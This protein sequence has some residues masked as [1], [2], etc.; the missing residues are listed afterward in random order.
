MVVGMVMVET[1]DREP[2]RRNDHF[3]VSRFK[4]LIV[5]GAYYAGGH[6][7]GE[8]GGE[9]FFGIPWAAIERAELAAVATVILRV[10]ADRQRHGLTAK[11]LPVWLGMECG[12]IIEG[13]TWRYAFPEKPRRVMDD[14]EAA[15]TFGLNPRTAEEYRNAM[16]RALDDQW[17]WTMNYEC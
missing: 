14:A 1:D 10:V 5:L 16:Q 13:G 7:Y 11:H 12:I 2:I 17:N 9:T 6:K 15:R 8:P 4:R 3:P